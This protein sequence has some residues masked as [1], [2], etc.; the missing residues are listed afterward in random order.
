MKN[1]KKAYKEASALIQPVVD[2]HGF[3]KYTQGPMFGHVSVYSPVEQHVEQIL[4]VADWLLNET[5]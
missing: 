2:K 3:Q 1:R 5:D 4:R